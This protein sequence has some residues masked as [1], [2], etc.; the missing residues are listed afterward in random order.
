MAR[1]LIKKLLR[2]DLFLLLA[3]VCILGIQSTAQAQSQLQAVRLREIKDLDKLDPNWIMGVCN[4]P[5]LEC[6]KVEVP[7][8]FERK[9]ETGRE[10][11]AVM[12]N[13]TISR[14]EMKAPGQWQLLNRWSFEKYPLP[15][16]QDGS[17]ARMID[18]HP[19]LYPAGPGLWAVA[20]LDDKLESYS[21]G[22]AQFVI[23]DFVTLDPAITDIDE[24]QRKFGNIPFSC[25]KTV[26]ACFTEKEH[27]TSPHCHDESTGYLTLKYA[28]TTASRY[29][30][31]TAT[32]NETSWPAGV[33]L[34][35]E[36]TTQQTL[37]LKPDSKSEAFDAFAFCDG[38]PAGR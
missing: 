10:F 14:L 13:R 2:L 6:N 36:K 33:P 21:G 16:A 9:T 37:A 22:G 27:K 5:G 32:W 3:A 20:V 34:S 38:G 26:R 1:H 17:E 31:W 11:Y 15:T 28:A 4:L 25:N 24:D 12:V 29:Y 35:K 8:L 30:D 7:R 18:I 23:A 19:A